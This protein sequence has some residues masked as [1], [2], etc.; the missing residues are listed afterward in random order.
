MNNITILQKI[1]IDKKI[2]LK[3]KKN[4]FPTKKLLKF[5]KPSKKNFYHILKNTST[6]FILE[7]KKA[8][9]L[10][11]I[12]CPNFN[13]V[14]IAK[15]YKNYASVISVV[16]EEKY[17]KGNFEF[18]KEISLIVNQPILCKDFIIDTW[19]V[20][21]AR[22]YNADAI[23]LMLS[24][25]DDYTY[26]KCVKIAHQ[27]NMGVLTEI[28]NKKELKRALLLKAMVIGINNRNLHDLSIDL[29][30]TKYL[31]K[32]L[33]KNIISISESGISNYSQIRELKKYVNGFLIGTALMKEKNL[34]IAVRKILLGENKICGLTKLRDVYAI[35]KF[36]AV[37]GGLIFIPHSERYISLKIA[38]KIII[39]N[40]FNIKYVGVFFNESI[41]KIIYI[42]NTL[43]LFAVQLHGEEDIIYIETLNKLLPKNCKIWKAIN[44]QCNFKDYKNHCIHRYLLD[45]EYGGTGKIFNWEKIKQ[46]KVKNIILA[47][48]ISEKNCKIASS[49][50]ALG[51][52]L[53]SGIE[54]KPGI[55]DHQKL[56][57]VFKILK[58]Y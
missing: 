27:L 46:V 29:N 16:T 50:G 26:I 4:I 21:F 31:S 39:N 8:T 2:W 10:K 33:P 57:L 28:H 41:K 55:K 17:F 40:N 20:Y 44:M 45:N 38:K 6:P 34:L 56:S 35:D 3:N 47:G 1:L 43:N 37:Y 23:L 7:C 24:I 19:Q 42:V 36:G 32:M 25:L 58:S 48:G 22:F 5:L 49:L 14:K 51:L 52:D 54:L 9:P 30:N 18:L 13:L 15:I 12:I 53:N 11:G